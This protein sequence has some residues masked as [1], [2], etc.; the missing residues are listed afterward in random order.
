MGQTMDFKEW[1]R[2]HPEAVREWRREKLLKG[3]RVPVDTSIF[4]Y[5]E[6]AEFQDWIIDQGIHNLQGVA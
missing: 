3:E 1:A 5:Y 4:T 6:W 2:N